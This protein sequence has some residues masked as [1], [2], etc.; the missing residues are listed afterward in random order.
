MICIK[1]VKVL[2]TELDEVLGWLWSIIWVLMGL[3]ILRAK[4]I[5]YWLI[6]YTCVSLLIPM[7]SI[8]KKNILGFIT[9]AHGRQMID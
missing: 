7:Q 9:H 6:V 4:H 5:S 3:L 1:G 8:R 2:T